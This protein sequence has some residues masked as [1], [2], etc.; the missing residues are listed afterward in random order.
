MTIDLTYQWRSSDNEIFSAG[1]GLGFHRNIRSI[2][3]VRATIVCV[4]VSVS[5]K[6]G[7]QCRNTKLISMRLIGQ[8]ECECICTLAQCFVRLN[9]LCECVCVSNRVQLLLSNTIS[10]AM[11]SRKNGQLWSVNFPT[12]SCTYSCERITRVFGKFIFVSHTIRT[13][14]NNKEEWKPFFGCWL[15]LRALYAWVLWCTHNDSYCDAK[16]HWHCCQNANTKQY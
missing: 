5:F 1:I 12:I 11:S 2:V 10:N 6:V 14:P 13:S 9:T 8:V 3:C 15:S 4:C 7:E 16:W